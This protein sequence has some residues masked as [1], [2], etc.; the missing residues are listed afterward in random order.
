MAL[1]LSPAARGKL[2]N[3]LVCFSL[4]NLCFLRRWYDLEHLKERSMDYYRSHPA[5]PTLL[6]AT[7]I[8]AF[9][10]TGVFWTA[11]AWVERR[12]T[13]A[14]VKLAACVFLLCLIYPLES[15]RRYWNEQATK[16]DLVSNIVLLGLEAALAVGVALALTGNYRVAVAARRVALVLTLLFP[17]LILDFTWSSLSAARA[18]DFEPR[19]PL[20]MLPVHAGRRVIWLLFDE[21]DQRLAFDLRKPAGDLPE[22]ERLRGASFVANRARQTAEWTTLAVP[23]LLSGTSL[24]SDQLVDA[25][26]LLVYPGHSSQGVNWRDQPNVFKRVRDLGLNGALVGWHHPYCR[27]IGGDTVRCMDLTSGTPTPALIRETSATDLGLCKTV[28]DL[29]FLQAA[30]VRDIFENTST[31]RSEIL[32]DEF[33]QRRQQGQYFQLR[34][35]AFADAADPQISFLFIHLPTPHL[36]GIYNRRRGDFTLDRSLSYAD[37]LALVDRTVG[38]LR[39]VLERAGLWDSTTLL[40]TSDHGL[41]PNLWRGHMGW[42]PELEE[43]TGGVQSPLVP[44]I[45]KLA[46]QDAGMVY[47]KPFSNALC[48]DFVLAELSGKISTAADAAAWL[49]QHS[50]DQPLYDSP[51]DHVTAAR[52]GTANMTVR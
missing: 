50:P 30:S 23:S 32:K 20:P 27:I 38:E 26:T 34:D 49:D 52:H 43:L 42:T 33:V 28:V 36:F 24:S 4:G 22:L 21:F 6:M 41:R 1:S 17:S 18:A 47:D 19:R 3:L 40:I 13:P 11:W 29:F 35:A 45:A 39:V 8:G 46:G 2:S 9:V 7:L 37:N 31:P 48:A 15:V 51:A 5:A 44:F 25:N 10:L 16:V 14:K 12:P